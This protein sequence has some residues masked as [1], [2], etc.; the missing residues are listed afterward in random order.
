MTE[1]AQT[2]GGGVL[3]LGESLIGANVSDANG[4]EMGR[5]QDI[6]GAYLQV[7]ASN[8]ASY[9]IHSAMVQSAETD[10][11]VFDFASEFVD[12]FALDTPG[13]VA[14]VPEDDI[15]EREA[16]ARAGTM[17]RI[18][19]HDAM[20][21][22]AQLLDAVLESYPAEDT[23]A[24][25]LRLRHAA[26]MLSEAVKQHRDATEAE[27]GALQTLAQ[28]KPALVRQIERQRREHFE[29][30]LKAE[31]LEHEVREQI[32][33]DRLDGDTARLAAL[34]LRESLRLHIYRATNLLYEAYFQEEGGEEG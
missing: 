34:I 2:P 11:V 27:G 17:P 32:A 12:V 6:Q 8:R 9:W 1:L 3:E 29:L 24:W 31:E 16:A 4:T 23:V 21:R 18:Q 20:E 15:A 25:G 28:V 7:D 5:V 33:F 26:R 10:G 14:E 19:A 13:F 30:L 22:S